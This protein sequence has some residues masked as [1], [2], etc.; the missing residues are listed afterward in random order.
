MR[1]EL[2]LGLIST[3]AWFVPF[4][5]LIKTRAE[6]PVPITF[7]EMEI[8]PF[9]SVFHFII[10]YTAIHSNST[11]SVR[12]TYGNIEGHLYYCIIAFYRYEIGI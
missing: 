4:G 3:V 5:K 12:P 7:I 8:F 1:L 10:G 6:I 9:L 11:Y 2:K